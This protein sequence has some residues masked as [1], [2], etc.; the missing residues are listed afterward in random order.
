[1]RELEFRYN[2]RNMSSLEKL[3]ELNWIFEYCSSTCNYEFYELSDLNNFSKD[4]YMEHEE[5][6]DK[7][8]IKN[9]RLLLIMNF[10]KK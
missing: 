8:M 3:K 6:E 2:T 10:K 5:N 9:I 7:E 4:N 1:L